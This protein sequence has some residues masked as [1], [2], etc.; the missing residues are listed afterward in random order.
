VFK[1]QGQAVFDALKAEAIATGQYGPPQPSSNR[2]VQPDF[3]RK[4]EEQRA[5]RR[6]AAAKQSV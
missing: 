5:R 2:V 3:S 6:R 1:E 4:L